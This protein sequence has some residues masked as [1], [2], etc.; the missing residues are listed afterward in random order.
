ML[1]VGLANTRIST[2]FYAQKSPRLLVSV[3]SFSLYN[4]LHDIFIKEFLFKVTLCG[5]AGVQL[6]KIRSYLLKLLHHL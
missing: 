5:C 1:P 2:G 6:Y 4:D 3:Y